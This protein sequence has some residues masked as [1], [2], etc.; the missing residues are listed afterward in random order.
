MEMYNFCELNNV[1]MPAFI[2]AEQEVVLYT[3]GNRLKSR[4]QT[5]CL[6]YLKTCLDPAPSSIASM[7]LE[8]R[9]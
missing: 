7:H 5:F 6:P 1:E 8:I 4:R 3:L 2:K 9:D